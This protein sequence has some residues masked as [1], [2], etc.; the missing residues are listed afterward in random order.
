RRAICRLICQVNFSI[1][2]FG[3]EPRR[4]PPGAVAARPNRWGLRTGC[5]NL[6]GGVP[7]RISHF[8]PAAG[9]DDSR[10]PPAR[11]SRP[12]QTQGAVVSRRLLSAAPLGLIHSRWPWGQGMSGFGSRK[13][14]RRAYVCRQLVADYDGTN[15][16]ARSDFYWVTFQNISETGAA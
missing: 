10:H 1:L 6:P 3:Y 15:L 16:P 8:G 11:I 13:S 9:R 12:S 7:G 4:T 14:A 2:H 5:G